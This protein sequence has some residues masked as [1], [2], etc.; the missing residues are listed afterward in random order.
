MAKSVRLLDQKRLQEIHVENSCRIVNYALCVICQQEKEEKLVDPTASKRIDKEIGY[1]SIAED[2]VNANTLGM[3]PSSLELGQLD[4]EET[5]AQCL[6]INKAVWHKSCCLKFNRN[7]MT[8]TEKHQSSIDKNSHEN[9]ENNAKRTRSSFPTYSKKKSTTDA[10]YFCDTCAAGD[11]L[12]QA[13]TFGLDNRV[14]S[15]A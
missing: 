7:E 12:R 9:E 14:R 8:R 3:L 6:K 10:C 11:N 1:H 2:L 15:A 5:V 4:N 13:Q